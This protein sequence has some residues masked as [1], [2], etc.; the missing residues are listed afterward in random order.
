MPRSINEKTE[1]NWGKSFLINALII[2]EKIAKGL[3]SVQFI[4]YL[5]IY[6]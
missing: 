1:V 3:F 5:S 6:S 2:I 4:L